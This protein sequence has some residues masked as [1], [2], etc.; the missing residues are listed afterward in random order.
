MECI[1]RNSS[2]AD[3]L[4]LRERMDQARQAHVA[5]KTES[6]Q[7]KQAVKA[8][9]GDALAQVVSID[10][11]LAKE[12]APPEPEPEPTEA[13]EEA[14]VDLDAPPVDRQVTVVGAEGL[15]QADGLLGASDPYAVVTFGGVEVGRTDVLEDTLN[16]RWDSRFLTSV[17]PAGGV[18][19]VEVYDHD[20]ASAHDFLGEAEVQLRRG[21]EATPFSLPVH[22]YPLKPSARNPGK[23]VRGTVT[24]SVEQ[25]DEVEQGPPVIGVLRITVR[26]AANLPK[27]DSLSHTDA[28]VQLEVEEA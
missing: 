11:Q 28:Y 19:R 25:E 2:Y 8:R 23:A 12:L 13:A 26:E 10:L 21:S 4:A 3:V 7:A 18:L 16:P 15:L 27:M 17:P 20:V 14:A 22:S 1:E 6:R 9:R 5:A 24:F